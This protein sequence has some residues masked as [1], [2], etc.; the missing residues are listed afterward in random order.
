MSKKNNIAK[1]TGNMGKYASLRGTLSGYAK[2]G[3]VFTI[4]SKSPHVVGLLEFG[5]K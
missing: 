1:E 2:V 4:E 3:K 5:N